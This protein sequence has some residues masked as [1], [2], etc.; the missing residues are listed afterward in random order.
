VP[1]LIVCGS[2]DPVTT[3]EHGRFMQARID[4]AELVEFDA[5]HLSIVEVGDRFTKRVLDFLLG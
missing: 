4:G 1:T 5:A 2:K 3:P